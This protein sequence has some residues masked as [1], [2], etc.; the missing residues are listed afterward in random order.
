MQMISLFEYPRTRE[1]LHKQIIVIALLTMASLALFLSKPLHIDDVLW[2]DLGRRFSDPHNYYSGSYYMFGLRHESTISASHPIVVPFLHFLVIQM[3][4]DPPEAFFHLAFLLFTVSATLFTYT[5]ALR[6]SRQPFLVAVCVLFSPPFFIVATNLITDVVMYAFVTGSLVFYIRAMDRADRGCLIAAIVLFALALATGFQS[7]VFYLA[8]FLYAGFHPVRRWRYFFLMG[9]SLVPLIAWYAYYIPLVGKVPDLVH[10]ELSPLT[11]TERRTRILYFLTQFSLANLVPIGL[12][13]AD[14]RPGRS[15][16]L[17]IG[18]GLAGLLFFIIGADIL[19]PYGIAKKILILLGGGFTLTFF[20]DG[21]LYLFRKSRNLS[22]CSGEEKDQLF[23]WLTAGVFFVI[24]LFLTPF[25]TSRYL[26]PIM[27]LCYILLLRHAEPLRL[28]AVAVGVALVGVVAILAARGDLMFAEFCKTFPERIRTELPQNRTVW[29]TGE[30]GFR[31]YM[32]KAGYR[33]LQMDSKVRPGDIILE[34]S[35]MS[36]LETIL[37]PARKRLRAVVS[38]RG[39]A[40]F[41][42]MNYEA[43]AGFWGQHWGL[44]PFWFGRQ[45]LETIRVHEVL[46][47]TLPFELYADGSDSEPIKDEAVKEGLAPWV[48]RGDARQALKQAPGNKFSLNLQPTR[49]TRLQFATAAVFPQGA[50]ALPLEFQV[51]AHWG[52]EVRLLYSAVKTPTTPDSAVW[53]PFE[54]D[55]ADFI[56]KNIRLE[57]RLLAQ[58]TTDAFGLWSALNRVELVEMGF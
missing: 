35:V 18:F 44:L 4:D 46:P 11:D 40:G 37:F 16:R 30:W 28:P 36:R 12:I 56:G 34:P 19:A 47:D 54:S 13:I 8:F 17:M 32:K 24:C 23:L 49:S 15:K 57:F 45:P 53:E 14:K 7:G 33:Y 38:V 48:L 3:F 20:A 2:Q 29:F 9:L 42:L 50:G 52:E 43:Q 39:S 26:F 25:A 1:M 27:S 51:T 6:F 55:L 5:L 10:L 31:H 21:A 22:V 58:G 41:R